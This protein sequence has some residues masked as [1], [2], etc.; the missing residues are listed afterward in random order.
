MYAVK[1]RFFAR[2]PEAKFASIREDGTLRPPEGAEF[3]SLY[4]A[5]MHLFRKHEGWHVR[6][7][8]LFCIVSGIL[9]VFVGVLIYVE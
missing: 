1:V 8:W 6:L 2:H 4:F 7:H 9:A 5:T 3:G